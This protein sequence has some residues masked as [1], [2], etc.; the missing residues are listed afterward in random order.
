MSK[1]LIELLQAVRQEIVDDVPRAKRTVLT[2]AAL[3]ALDAAA[4]PYQRFVE[5]GHW[6]EALKVSVIDHA[7]RTLQAASRPVPPAEAARPAEASAP[8]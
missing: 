7:L 4:E 2:T 6:A 8:A 5:R 1:P 3:E